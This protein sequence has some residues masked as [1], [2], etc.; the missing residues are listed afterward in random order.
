VG[1]GAPAGAYPPGA[2]AGAC[3]PFLLV[4]HSSSLTVRTVVVSAAGGLTGPDG[5]RL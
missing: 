3:S 4:A 2:P 1:T 5:G